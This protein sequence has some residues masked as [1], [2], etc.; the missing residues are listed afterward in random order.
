MKSG[1]RHEQNVLLLMH[2]IQISTAPGFFND[3][4]GQS[5]ARPLKSYVNLY[6]GGHPFL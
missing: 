4:H 6:N 2:V 5:S 1:V 3:S